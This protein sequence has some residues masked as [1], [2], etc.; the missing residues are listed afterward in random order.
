M[1]PPTVIAS[2]L[3]ARTAKDSTSF[4]PSMLYLILAL[5]S[6]FLIVIL[7]VFVRNRIAPLF[8]LWYISARYGRYSFEFLEFFKANDLRNPHNNCIK[9]EVTLRFLS[10]FKPAKNALTFKTNILVEFGDTPFLTVY[11]GLMNKKGTPDCI[12][13]AKFGEARV[14]VIGYNETLQGM[15]MKSLFYFINDK[16]V[17]GEYLF[18]E[19]IKVKPDKILA[20]I[21]AKYLDNKE[22]KTDALYLTDAKGNILFYNFNGFAISMSYFFAGDHKINE[23]LASVYSINGNSAENYIRAL[24][25]EEM[26]NR[27]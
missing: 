8:R 13:I 11:K 15:K 9:D 21:S 25:N 3:L 18:S 17:M 7:L 4:D 24:Q 6:I 27:F 5:V 20:I 10:F 26:L 1:T 22:L 23:I 14:K 19:L 2:I 12:N 16:F